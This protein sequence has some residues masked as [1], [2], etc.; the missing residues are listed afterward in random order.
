MNA[1]AIVFPRD[2][3]E[4]NTNTDPQSSPPD[5]LLSRVSPPPFIWSLFPVQWPMSSH[6]GGPKVPSRST[7]VAAKGTLPRVDSA[8]KSASRVA[9]SGTIP[10]GPHIRPNRNKG[11]AHEGRVGGGED[12]GPSSLGPLSAL[13]VFVVVMVLPNCSETCQ[14]IVLHPNR[15]F[16]DM[17]QHN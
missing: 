2:L 15:K 12:S 5:I 3:S 13:P 16:S 14:K 17:P 11:G 10:G 4:K 6:M 1:V 8:Q 9:S 7:E